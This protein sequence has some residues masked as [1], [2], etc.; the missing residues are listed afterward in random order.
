MNKI[1]NH[2]SSTIG[3]IFKMQH[4]IIWYNEE[5]NKMSHTLKYKRLRDLF[6][7]K[8]CNIHKIGFIIIIL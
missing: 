4:N 1:S 2:S 8:Q 3:I 6:E 5:E 7:W